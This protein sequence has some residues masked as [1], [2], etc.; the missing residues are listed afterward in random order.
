MENEDGVDVV[1]TC[2]WCGARVLRWLCCGDRTHI[3]RSQKS[4]GCDCRQKLDEYAMEAFKAFV[5]MDDWGTNDGFASS[6]FDLAEA[7]VIERA[8][9]RG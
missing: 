7:M 4:P 6:A 2:K 9:R 3:A 8:K 5:R 1:S